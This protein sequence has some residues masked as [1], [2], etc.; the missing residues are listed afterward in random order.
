MEDVKKTLIDCPCSV[1]V[2]IV[3]FRGDRLVKILVT[4]LR[5]VTVG[6]RPGCIFRSDRIRVGAWLPV[7]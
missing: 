7:G 2:I 3:S 4:L 6:S 1:V 5:P